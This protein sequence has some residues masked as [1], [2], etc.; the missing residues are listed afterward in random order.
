[1]LADVF[2]AIVAFNGHR[3]KPHPGR[4]WGAVKKEHYGNAK[5]RTPQ[6]VA[7]LLEAAAAGQFT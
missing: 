1:M 7:Q 5:G 3:N 6:Q 2:D 4:P